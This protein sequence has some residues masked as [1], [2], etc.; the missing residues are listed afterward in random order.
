MFSWRDL[1]WALIWFASHVLVGRSAGKR[2]MWSGP[3]ILGCVTIASL[4]TGDHRA[5]VVAGEATVTA[6]VGVLVGSRRPE[7]R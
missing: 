4:I 1:I 2:L 5:A 3:V 7:V 6:S